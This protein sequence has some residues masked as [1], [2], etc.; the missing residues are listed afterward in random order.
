MRKRDW[1]AFIEKKESEGRCRLCGIGGRL[2]AAH[3]IPRSRIPVHSGLAEDARNC[4]PLCPDCHRRVD[5]ADPRTGFRQ[6][7]IHV[8]TPQE[9]AYCVE[10]VGIEEAY[11]RLLGRRLSSVVAGN[12]HG[13][14]LQT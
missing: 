13:G 3:I 14:P 4:V 6:G 11:G 2:E 12:T 9:Q 7:L 1:T 10:L 8:T 5:V